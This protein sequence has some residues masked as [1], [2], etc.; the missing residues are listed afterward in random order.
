MSRIKYVSVMLLIMSTLIMTSC[1]G[2][3]GGI[4]IAPK[5]T[6]TFD[7]QG[8]GVPINPITDVKRGSAILEP[9]KPTSDGFIF[10]G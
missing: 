10:E 2:V 8:H 9:V 5:Y 3:G 1:M 7:I 6:V 4:N